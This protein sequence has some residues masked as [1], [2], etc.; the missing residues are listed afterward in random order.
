VDICGRTIVGYPYNSLNVTGNNIKFPRCHKKVARS[1]RFELPTFGIEIRCSLNA[2]KF[3]NL[4][5]T[6]STSGV[7]CNLHRP[8]DSSLLK[9]ASIR[10]A[11]MMDRPRQRVAPSALVAAKDVEQIDLL[12][13][14][15]HAS[16]RK[17][18][19]ECPAFGCIRITSMRPPNGVISPVACGIKGACPQLKERRAE[20]LFLGYQRR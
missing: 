13:A 14:G 7:D 8:L 17:H 19:R 18:A 3:H 5:S 16:A 9:G 11:A 12:V 1:E 4:R 20:A 2:R 6:K 15:G 10:N